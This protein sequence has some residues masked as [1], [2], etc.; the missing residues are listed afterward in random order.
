MS[1]AAPE[2]GSSGLTKQVVAILL[3]VVTVLG[4]AFGLDAALTS[5]QHVDATRA[6]EVTSVRMLDERSRAAGR[7]SAEQQAENTAAEQRA[8]AEALGRRDVRSLDLQ[9]ER[10]GALEAAR[11][12]EESSQLGPE[13]SVL[14]DT[15]AVAE[16]FKQRERRGYRRAFEFANGYDQQ[17]QLLGEKADSL[18]AV[19]A[20]L[21]IGV[22]LIGLTLAVTSSAAR[23]VLLGTGVAIALVVTVWGVNVASDDVAGP[24]PPAI[25]AYVRGQEIR[26]AAFAEISGGAERDRH[27][28]ALMRKSIS[29]F[30]EAI[31]LRP[32]YGAAHAGRAIALDVLAFTDPAGAHGS[33]GARDEYKRAYELG[34]DRPLMLN[35]LAIAELRLRN[36]GAAIKAARAA[37][38]LRPNVSNANETLASVLRYAAPKPT[39]AYRAQLQRLRATWAQTDA[40][41]RSDELARSIEGTQ[42]IAEQHPDLAARARAYGA[43]LE[44][45]V[46]ELD[47]R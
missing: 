43:D 20:V 45:I 42:E 34:N 18:L 31:R 8:N 9:V 13:H 15:S 35:N 19:T 28:R 24:S 40:K 44:R 12:A 3:M 11:G 47:R 16:R 32:D 2:P 41:R 29:D 37:V 26:R 21:G 33:T 25:D 46:G 36:I 17:K 7:I 1:G 30:D 23:K 6:V 4:G 38:A 39:P 27:A 5:D 14:R 10:R 22:F